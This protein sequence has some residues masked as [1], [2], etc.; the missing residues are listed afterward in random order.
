MFP[1][2]LDLTRVPVFLMGEGEVLA[3]RKTQLEEY[4]AANIYVC[5]PEQWL[6]AEASHYWDESQLVMVAGLEHALATEVATQA[7]H[8][9]KLVNVEDV[10]ELCD[11]YFTS[12]L[13]RGD[14]VI[15][16]STSGASPTLAKKVRDAIAERFGAEWEERTQIIAQLRQ[17]L[18]KSGAGMKE[19]MQK[20]ESFL[21]E[22]GWFA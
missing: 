13:R 15:A 19:I 18:K 12:N 22:K 2:V 5:T 1:I 7:R 14:L 10:N 4:G 9:K 17:G 21:A 6:N 20:T 8:Q 3:R 16:V 11:F